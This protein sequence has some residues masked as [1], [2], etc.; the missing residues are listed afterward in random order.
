MVERNLGGRDAD[1]IRLRIVSRLAA[2]ATLP[3]TGLWGSTEHEGQ[4]DMTAE[5]TLPN[6]RLGK[7]EAR[8]MSKLERV[9]AFD[10]LTVLDGNTY[11][12]AQYSAINRAAHGLH[13][14]GLACV[15][16]IRGTDRR[17]R[18]AAFVYLFRVGLTPE[19]LGERRVT[20]AYETRVQRPYGNGSTRC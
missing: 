12:K 11:T 6:P 9:A 13:R 10:P 8:L 1:I 18:R 14:K 3:T 17:G 2:C 19:A 15:Y 7:W 4:Q 5:R 16:R 20:T